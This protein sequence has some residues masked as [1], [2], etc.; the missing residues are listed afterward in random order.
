[1]KTASNT[2]AHRCSSRAT[3]WRITPGLLNAFTLIELLT[4]IALIAL[5]SAMLLPALARAKSSARQIKCASNLRQLALAGQMYWDDHEGHCFRWRGPATN[6]GQVYWFGWLQN[7]AEGQR[8]FDPRMGALFP[9]LEDRGVEICPAFNYLSPQFKLKSTG[10]SYGYGYNLALSSPLD[11]P[12]VNITRTSRP[13]ELAF[14][15]D[16]AQ[17]NAFQPP[18]SPQNPMLEEFYY[19]SAT[20]PTVHFRHQR[21]ANVAF[22]DGHISTEKPK[23]GSLDVR[24]PK[25]TIGQLEPELLRVD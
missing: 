18:A 11:Q 2:G 22:C 17:V 24:I 12:P 10:A 5:L 23:A 6:G 4:V 1:M 21:R 8:Q 19:L 16:S 3:A 14:L 9:Y 20:E 15:A 13:T 7:G 25:H